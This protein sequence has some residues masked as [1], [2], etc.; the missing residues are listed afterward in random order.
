MQCFVMSLKVLAMIALVGNG[1]G[2]GI[3]DSFGRQLLQRKLWWAGASMMASV[4]SREAKEG[5]KI[6]A[7]N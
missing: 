5:V 1:N 7:I 6:Y 4:G 3:N 2:I